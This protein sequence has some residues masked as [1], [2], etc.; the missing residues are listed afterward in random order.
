MSD[1]NQKTEEPQQVEAPAAPAESKKVVLGAWLFKRGKA[2]PSDYKKR[3]FTLYDDG[4]LGMT[5]A[6]RARFNRIADAEL[7]P[8]S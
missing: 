6:A 8:A 1:E 5:E 7:R 4:T 2:K 3:Y